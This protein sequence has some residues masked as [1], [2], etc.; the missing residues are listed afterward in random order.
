M[1]CFVFVLFRITL[2]T[3]LSVVDL[4]IFRNYRNSTFIS[5]MLSTKLFFPWLYR[6]DVIRINWHWA[7]VYN[8]SFAFESTNVCDTHE[9]KKMGK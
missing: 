9:R 6:A 7:R 5:N 8:A 2:L 1:F 4:P 3:W